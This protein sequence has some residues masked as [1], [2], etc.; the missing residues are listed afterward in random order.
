YVTRVRLLQVGTEQLDCA[1]YICLSFL[2]VEHANQAERMSH[3]DREISTRKVRRDGAGSAIGFQERQRQG[4]RG[5]LERGRRDSQVYQWVTRPSRL[6]VDDCS[7]AALVNDAL[8]R[9]KVAMT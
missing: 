6:P 3:A 5:I 1:S 9:V 2:D 8:D 4:G 7:N